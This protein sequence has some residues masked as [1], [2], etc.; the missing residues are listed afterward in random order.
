M[1][2]AIDSNRRP[3]LAAL[4]PVRL[5]ILEHNPDD[6]ERSI[7][8]LR[9]EGFDPEYRRIETLSELPELLRSEEWDIVL[10][11]HTPPEFDALAAL[12]LLR[13][14][15][16]E[17]PLVVVA[18]CSDEES[19]VN[20]LRQGV[21]DFIAKDHLYRLGSVTRHVLE[22]YE[23]QRNQYSLQQQL[24][25]SQKMEVIGTLAGGLA[26]DFNNL[27]TVIFGGLNLAR[28]AL[29]ADSSAMKHLDMVE[30]A[31]RQAVGITSSML[32]FSQKAPA[33]K[34]SAD[35]CA[36]CRD[37]QDILRRLL[38]ASITQSWRIP[39]EPIF[40][41]VDP[42]QIQQVLMNLAVNARDA[43]P[44]GG[45]L[46]VEFSVSTEVSAELRALAPSLTGPTVCLKVTD[47]GI[48]MDAETRSRVF[49][50]FFSTKSREQGTGLGLAVVRGI[51]RDHGGWCEVVSDP[52]E[53]AKFTLLLPRVEQ[54]QAAP[55]AESEERLSVPRGARVLIIEDDEQVRSLMISALRGIGFDVDGFGDCQTAGCRTSPKEH[56]GIG[57]TFDVVVA[58]VELPDARGTVCLRNILNS[59][60]S[61]RGLIIAGRTDDKEL[62]AEAQQLSCPVLYKP[63]GM[64]DFAEAVKKLAHE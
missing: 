25:Q 55:A 42:T 35:I 15:E 64:A 52:G 58:D 14:S 53:G 34:T 8:E 28:I 3:D 49:D 37:V 10:S 33:E 7:H 13:G 6:A 38:P 20:C 59:N 47:D 54:D 1:T 41:R 45:H 22:K 56:D 39:D 4:E 63:F 23:A 46:T 11:D 16:Q 31:A 62:P 18:G 27:L 9:L 2:K 26:H 51:V 32:T 50:P 44:D 61:S 21:D 36:L 48:G 5:I 17:I 40:A 43:L 24:L 30:Q 57:E 29:P 12:A 19:E 60:P